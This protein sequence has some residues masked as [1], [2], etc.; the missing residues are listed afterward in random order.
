MVNVKIVALL[1][2]AIVVIAGASLLLVQPYEKQEVTIIA[3]VNSEGS[4]IFVEDGITDVSQFGGNV[5]ATPGPA[6]IQHMMLMNYVLDNGLKWASA[7]SEGVAKQSD[8]VYW[9]R[10]APT[11]MNKT[12][13]DGT[14]NG[15]IA[16]EPY[17]SEIVAAGNANIYKWSD[18][19]VAAHP[20]CVLAV[21]SKFLKENPR[22]VERYLAAHIL[23]TQ[24]I[25]DTFE[26]GPSANYTL[27]LEMGAD[28]AGIP[29]SV[30]ED[31]L[32]HVTFNYT[33]DAVWKQAL[34]E[35]VQT[36]SDLGQFDR[37][38][39]SMGYNNSAEFVEEF[40]D[41]KPLQNAMSLQPLVEGSA[42]ED[43][44]VG[45]LA[46]DIHQ[47]ARLVGM[48]ETVGQNFGFG[49]RTIFEAHGINVIGGDGNPYANGGFVMDAFFNKAIDI[50]YL[51]APPAVLKTV[52]TV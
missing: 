1:I 35:V 38:L 26:G 12:M 44:R 19:L 18:E 23:A 49:D 47:L 25:V 43:V 29:E 4:A 22:T 15:G 10:V 14:I 50:G 9:V 41:V 39:T 24:W 51:G 3:Q 46:G 37:T 2:V 34:E 16:W 36:Y 31:S 17:N 33:M 32:G 21:N 20:C 40:V 45:W 8:T 52:N 42:L 28:F 48:N 5:F 30:V 27:L 11:N 6:S 7:P 13:A